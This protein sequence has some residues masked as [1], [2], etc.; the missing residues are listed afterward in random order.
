MSMTR[1]VEEH[2]KLLTKKDKSITQL[3][4]MEPDKD[5][6]EEAAKVPE[7]KTKSWRPGLA[8][9][10]VIARNSPRPRTGPASP[11]SCSSCPTRRRSP[12]AG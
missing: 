9:L 12:A 10:A 11:P 2:Q 8:N 5:R 3:K 6:D 4:K 1:M 7:E